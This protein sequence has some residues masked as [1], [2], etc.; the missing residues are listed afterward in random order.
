MKNMFYKLRK[1]YLENLYDPSLNLL[2][3]FIILLI[4]TFLYYMVITNYDKAPNEVTQLKPMVE[5]FFTQD[6]LKVIAIVTLL[7]ELLLQFLI[8]KPL[9]QIT[10]KSD[11]PSKFKTTYV[12]EEPFE[13]NLTNKSTYFQKYIIDAN[14]SNRQWFLFPIEGILQIRGQGKSKI[15]LPVLKV[16][17]TT[18]DNDRELINK[19]QP[20][21][22]HVSR[23]KRLILTPVKLTN[24]FWDVGYKTIDAYNIEHITEIYLSD[25][26]K[27]NIS[28]YMVDEEQYQQD[29]VDSVF[30]PTYRK[31]KL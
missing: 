18:I 31:D 16:T 5:T 23:R 10:V 13:V 15:E 12:E 3:L 6:Y 11:K 4:T 24:Y 2:T 17:Q 14:D 19:Y 29:L 28:G 20:Y 7:F 26:E 30:N 1:F 9:I 27:S 22:K 21:I 25:T 8:G